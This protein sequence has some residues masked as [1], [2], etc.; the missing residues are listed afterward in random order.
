MTPNKND[1]SSLEDWLFECIPCASTSLKKEIP[2]PLYRYVITLYKKGIE[3]KLQTLDEDLTFGK[4]R[5]LQRAYNFY[6]QKD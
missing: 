1:P 4:L 6:Y 3:Y 5:C 2:L